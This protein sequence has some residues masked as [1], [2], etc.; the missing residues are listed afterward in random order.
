MRRRRQQPALSPCAVGFVLGCALFFASLVAV[1]T[2]LVGKSYALASAANAHAGPVASRLHSGR[3]LAA[4]G[5]TES[6]FDNGLNPPRTPHTSLRDYEPAVIIEA[7]APRYSTIALTHHL[8]GIV[9]IRAIIGA[10]GTPRS[11]TRIS[12]DPTLAQIAIDAISLWRYRP[13][14]VDGNLVE[15]EIII[16]TVFQLPN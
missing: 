15:S 6:A 8:E 12:G 4:V 1:R 5:F 7:V 3:P 10:D 9:R 14:T 2:L 13:A 11:L 16:R